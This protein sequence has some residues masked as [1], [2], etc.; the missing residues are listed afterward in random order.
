MLCLLL[1]AKVRRQGRNRVKPDPLL[2]GGPRP[3]RS[4]LYE[5][6]CPLENTFQFVT[7]RFRTYLLTD[8]HHWGNKVRKPHG[9]WIWKE[10]LLLKR[11]KWE[12]WTLL[13]TPT[14]I[15]HWL[16]P[17][18]R[19][20]VILAWEDKEIQIFPRHYL[21]YDQWV[22][23]PFLAWLLASWALSSH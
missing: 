17:V 9:T 21:L 22:L 14:T 2:R 10:W 12:W 18:T 8:S 4:R 15:L 16:K 13:T 11:T 6:A 20:Q 7:P 5:F 3:W 23:P 19:P 1:E